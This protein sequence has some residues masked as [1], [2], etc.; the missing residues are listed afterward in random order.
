MRAVLGR[1]RRKL[2]CKQRACARGGSLGVCRHTVLTVRVVGKGKQAVQRIILVAILLEVLVAPASVADG[3]DMPEKQQSDWGLELMRPDRLV[4]WDYGATAPQGWRLEAGELVGTGGASPLVSGFTFGD[5]ELRLEWSV[6]PGGACLIRLGQLDSDRGL[7]ITLNDGAECGTIAPHDSLP[8]DKQGPHGKPEHLPAAAPA[9]SPSGPWHSATIVRCGGQLRVQVD[10]RWAHEA[11]IAPTA[12]YGLGLA[13]RGAQGRF[14]QLRVQEPRG[15]P[16]FTGKNLEGWWTPGA[17]SAW[18]FD[19]GTLV[20]RG[21][22]G[23]YL[24]SRKEY[25]NFTLSLEYRIQKGG[26]SGIGIR[27]PP[28]GW[29]STEGMELQ[30]WDVP[31]ERPLDKHAPMAIYGNVPPLCRADRS[32]QWNRL[33]IKADGPIVS[34]WVNGR[35]VQHCNTA[36]HPELKHRYRRGWIGIQDHGARIEIRQMCILEAPDGDGPAAW[37]T[38]PP[39]ALTLLLERLPNSRQLAEPDGIRSHVAIA[40]A[41]AGDLPVLLADVQ[42]P[43]ALVRIAGTSDEGV[44]AF[45]FDGQTVPGLEC[46]PA[47]LVH[48]LPHLTEDANPL[49]TCVAFRHR[50]RVVLRQA[51]EAQYRLEYVTFPADLPLASWSAEAPGVPASWLAAISYRREQFG[52]GVHREHDPYRRVQGQAKE[53]PPGKSETLVRVDGAGVVHWVKLLADKKLLESR[54]LWLEAFTDGRP[55]PDVA[56]PVRYWFPGL[57]GQGNFQNF[58]LVERGGVTNMLAMPFS[59]GIRLALSNRGSRSIRN[60]GLAV[61]VHTLPSAST[62]SLLLNPMRLRALYRPASLTDSLAETRVSGAAGRWI[63]VVCEAGG[64]ALPKGAFVTIDGHEAPGWGPTESDLFFGPPGDF[65]TCGAGR[66]GALAWRYLLLEAVDF[67]KSFAL[68]WP[69]DTPPEQLL[70]FYVRDAN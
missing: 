32:G 14:R 23:N 34:A 19:N 29:P 15:V 64:K 69:A 60:V 61:S 47:E 35:L 1:P 48:A 45:Y 26:N 9:A 33:V 67:Q 2:R 50:L 58:V 44:L 39:S 43:G 70:I 5:F 63:G 27:T 49:L 17:L 13:I 42:G 41:R 31:A 8:H 24:R 12:R 21:L 65:R 36:W 54:D 25:A 52:W 10:G 46:R 66:R 53:I 20:L 59:R 51:K 18:H 4:G 56:T 57:A 55:Q 30:I 3:A 11:T 16:M 28:A 37:Q 7:T 40:R 6:A 62:G 68:R 38:A 22:G